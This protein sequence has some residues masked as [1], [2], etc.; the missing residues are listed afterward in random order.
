[1]PPQQRMNHHHDLVAHGLKLAV[2]QDKAVGGGLGRP[3]GPRRR[4]FDRLKRYC[5][6]QEQTLF[7]D[8]ELVKAVDDMYQHP[9]LESA[10][11]LLMRLL[12]SDVSDEELANA[13]KSLREEGRLTYTEDDA[14]L[15][16]PRVVCS[17]GLIPN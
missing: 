17:M 6:Q 12:R 3:S 14:K 7:Q 9:L 2:S 11:D 13:V 10:S 8:E 4:S 15:R 16:E 1:T 5:E